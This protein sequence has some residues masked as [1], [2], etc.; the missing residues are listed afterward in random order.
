MHLQFMHDAPISLTC[1]DEKKFMNYEGSML[2]VGKSVGDHMFC[3]FFFCFLLVLIFPNM[4]VIHILC[5]T[6]SLTLQRYHPD[7]SVQI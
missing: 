2:R 3:V 5:T 1:F 6:Y 4:F 7:L